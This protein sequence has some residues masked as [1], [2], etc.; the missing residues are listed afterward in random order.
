[1]CIRDSYRDHGHPGCEGAPALDDLPDSKPPERWDREGKMLGP[2]GLLLNS[3]AHYGMQAD[4]TLCVEDFRGIRI[5]LMELPQ[6]HV[7][8]WARSVVHR[9]RL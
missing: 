1:M 7:K 5:P 8:P 6:Q 3:I 4:A 9:H 2:L